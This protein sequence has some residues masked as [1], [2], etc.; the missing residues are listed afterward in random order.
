MVCLVGLVCLFIVLLNTLKFACYSNLY[1]IN[2]P[3]LSCL[4]CLPTRHFFGCT[5]CTVAVCTVDSLQHHCTKVLDRH[6]KRCVGQLARRD[7]VCRLVFWVELARHIVRLL[8]NLVVKHIQAH[9]IVSQITKVVDV[10]PR[11]GRVSH[12]GLASQG[13]LA[14]VQ[15]VRHIGKASNF[16]IV[17]VKAV[18]QLWHRL[19]VL[20]ARAEENRAFACASRVDG[21]P[22][23]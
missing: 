5:F 10:E 13:V 23:L 12:L 17:G 21:C 6:G 4:S 2:L 19:A 22:G 9:A 1:A 7:L 16:C 18:T 15:E 3:C 20:V 11:V 8:R 14:V